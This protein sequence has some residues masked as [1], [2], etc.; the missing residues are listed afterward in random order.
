[1]F[2]KKI[3]MINHVGSEEVFIFT[4]PSANLR[5]ERG[6]LIDGSKEKS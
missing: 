4:K 3:V 6:E 5:I 1:M 2:D